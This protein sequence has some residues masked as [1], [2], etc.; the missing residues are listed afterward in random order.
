MPSDVHM[1]AFFHGG[2]EGMWERNIDCLLSN[3]YLYEQFYHMK[4]PAEFTRTICVRGSSW[5]WLFTKFK[6]LKAINSFL[7][8]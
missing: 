5:T 4:N 3:T 1:L 8:E 7:S 6:P 2:I